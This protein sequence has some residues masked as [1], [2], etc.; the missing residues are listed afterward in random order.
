MS[1]PGT[2]FAILPTVV[3]GKRFGTE[4]LE[5]FMGEWNSG[6]MPWWVEI[7]GRIGLNEGPSQDLNLRSGM[8]PSNQPF[9]FLV[10]NKTTCLRSEGWVLVFDAPHPPL[11]MSQDFHQGISGSDKHRSFLILCSRTHR[12]PSER[13]VE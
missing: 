12:L 8:F 6:N 1:D 2:W 13:V 7:G 3:S 9:F 11:S 5:G 4:S 10:D